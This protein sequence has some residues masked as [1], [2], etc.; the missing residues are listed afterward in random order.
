[1]GKRGE[2]D[3]PFETIAIVYRQE[4]LGLIKARL[5]HEGIWTVPHSYRHISIDVPITLALGGIRL[6][7]HREQAAEARELLAGL[8]PWERRGGVY[9]ESFALD[10]L[11]AL[12]LVLLTGIPPPCRI[13]SILIEGPAAEGA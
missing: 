2:P 9:A 3:G 6:M 10:L 8:P 11:M 1:M 12:L 7:V 13:D 5:E 4:E